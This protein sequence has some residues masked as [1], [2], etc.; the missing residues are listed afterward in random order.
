MGQADDVKSGLCGENG[1]SDISI[2]KTSPNN[3]PFSFHQT[4]LC[5]TCR[6][7]H[8]ISEESCFPVRAQSVP[9]GAT[10]CR[11]CVYYFFNARIINVSIY[12]E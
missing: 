9:F 2:S 10:P 7:E 3:A 4:L 5:V 11:G 6:G 8:L 1:F 12:I